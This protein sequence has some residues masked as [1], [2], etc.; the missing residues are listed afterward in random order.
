MIK[1]GKVIVFVVIA[2]FFG[3]GV[4]ASINGTYSDSNHVDID[5][6]TRAAE[7]K[8]AEFGKSN[9]FSICGETTVCDGGEKLF[10]VF[11]LKPAGYVVTSA[12]FAL[13]PV[14]A[15]SFKS[16]FSEGKNAL[17]DMLK[18]DINLRLKN[19]QN[20]P[21]HVIEE[22]KQ[23][24]KGVLS[25]N[26]TALNFEQWPPEG[27]TS[28]GGW[29]ETTWSQNSPYNDFCPLDG[30]ERSVAGCPAVAMAQIL[31]Y[32]KTTNGVFFND[33]D[34]YYHNYIHHYTIDDD[35]EEYD[36]PSFPELNG[37]LSNLSS[38]YES[39]V[40]ITD[41]DRAAI[42]FACGVAARQVYSSEVSGTF[43]VNQA[44]KAYLR[45]GI[46][47]IELLNESNPE[48]YGRLRMNM[49]DALP[50]HLAVVTPEWDSGHN[51]VVDGY[52]TDDYY[53]LNFG[54]GGS[55]DGWY[56][57]P[58]DMPYGLTVI[59]GVI[60][61]IM[62]KHSGSDIFC[63]GS[64]HW[65]D[66]EAGGTIHANFTVENAGEPNSTL[67][68]EVA[69]YP[70]WG[71]WAFNPS[72]GGNLSPGDKDKVGVSVTVPDKKIRNFKGYVK[73]VNR[74]D[75]SDFFILPV[76]VAT[77]RTHA[78]HVIPPVVQEILRHFPLLWKIMQ[79]FVL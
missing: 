16:N 66:V 10:Y 8:I 17:T 6:A 68:W 67:D 12:D 35:H 69:E 47:G 13:P 22:R 20:L 63:D 58:D 38:H 45:F 29:L 72:Q 11:H 25:G 59:E 71:T 27:T 2:L 53:H 36:F 1:K 44:Y 37:Y 51:L 32:H 79:D 78:L 62:A 39:G 26:I 75:S 52:N 41:N 73:V 54:W 40:N 48:L 9:D 76:S 7:A 60:V 64:L 5:T 21:T 19:I 30:G 70:E 24:W 57:L 46:D 74:D 43:G 49:V 50:A 28:T 4:L 65:A 18:A 55:L 33:S 14:I 42:V 3:S 23:M 15:Y 31:N 56:L 34:D 77:P 61:D